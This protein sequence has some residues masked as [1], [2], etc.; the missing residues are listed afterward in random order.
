MGSSKSKI[1]CDR[2]T[3]P[4]SGL[5]GI[6]K[7]S[8]TDIKEFKQYLSSLDEDADEGT[9]RTDWLDFILLVRKL[10]EPNSSKINKR[11]TM[12]EIH[13]IYFTESSPHRIVLSSTPL[14]KEC[15]RFQKDTGPI[16]KAHDDVLS[17]L[18][19]LSRPYLAQRQSNSSSPLQEMLNCIL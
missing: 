5:S 15:S 1:K 10:N 19:D 17:Q 8:E 13:N 14:W 18:E 3:T 11:K 12:E 7:G 9:L 4:P 6:L 16:F 2:P